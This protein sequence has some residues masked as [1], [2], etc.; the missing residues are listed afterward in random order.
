MQHNDTPLHMINERL[1]CIWEAYGLGSIQTIT[2]PARGSI[3]YY[4]IV[5][6]AYVIRFDITGK[7]VSRFQS[8]ALAY[9][10]LCDSG[11]PVP[12]VVALDRSK[13]LI[14]YEYLITT[15]LEGTP[16]IDSWSSLSAQQREQ[17][18]C[19]AG[20]YLAV[21]H[22]HTFDRFGKLRDLAS[23]G[24]ICWYD[25]S[26]DYFHRY[27]RQ[28]LDLGIIDISLRDR[29]QEILDQYRPLWDAVT[30]GS[31][32]H[33]DYHFENIL[34]HKGAVS[35][36]I[37]FEWSYPGDPTIDLVVE[38]LWEQM[39]PGS[40]PFV[41]AGYTSLSQL[42]PNH[43]LKMALYKLYTYLEFL[44]DSKRRADET[45]FNKMYAKLQAA[46]QAL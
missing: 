43:D 12:E 32:V 24:F 6:N 46:L 40:K 35:G 11:V 8:E 16:V 2:W 39:C 13:E 1:Q 4:L 29:M 38:D 33:S 44:V 20:R 41:Y 18:A 21:I 36:I 27:A 28:A 26:A 34:Q 25:Y 22:S 10:Y 17:V 45:E 37:D 31:L 30:K 15:R 14:P 7:I 9:R 3:N 5:N 42:D 19:E 23:G